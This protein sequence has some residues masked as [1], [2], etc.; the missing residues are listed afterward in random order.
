MSKEKKVNTPQPVLKYRRVSVGDLGRGRRG[1]HHDL[2]KGILQELKIAS[3]GSALEIPLA[4]VG[5][6]G[7]A[8]LRSA[9]HRAS[10]SEGFSIETLVDERNF[11]VWKRDSAN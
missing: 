6:I 9:V 5:G 3:A 11:Y 7:L 4:D 10:T 2:V 8:N 1:K